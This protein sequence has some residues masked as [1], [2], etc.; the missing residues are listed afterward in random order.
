MKNT[1]KQND[2]V[3]MSN[4]YDLQSL[5]DELYAKSKSGYIFYHLMEYI[6][7]PENIKLAY[8]SIKANKGSH[9]SGMDK[10]DIRYL[11]NMSEEEYVKYIQSKFRNYHPKAVRRKEIPK[12]NGKVRPLGIPCITDRIIQQCILQVLEP[13]CEAKFYDSSY[14]FRPLRSAENAISECSRRI[15]R[16][17]MQYVVDVDIKGF[18]DNV[19]HRKLLRQIWTLGIR[20]TRLQQIIKQILK[21]PI[22]MPDGRIEYPT[23]GTPQGGILSPLLAN[24]VLNELDWWI[25][26]QWHGFSEQLENP[27]KKQYNPN[28]QRN[29]GSEYR[30]MRKTQL[31]EMYIVRYA[32]DFKIFCKT[33]QDAVKIQYAVEDFLNVRLKLQVSKEKTGITNLKRKYCEFLGFKLKMTPKG[34]KYVVDARMSDKAVE[35]ATQ[36]L[37]DQV[38]Q[39]QH[40]KNGKELYQRINLYNTM[41]M[42]I[43]NYYGIANNVCKDLHNIQFQMNIVIK[44][45][46]NIDKEGEITNRVIK[47]RYG[48][49]KQVR[50]LNGIPIVPIG[51]LKSRTNYTP[52]EL[53]ATYE[54]AECEIKHEALVTAVRQSMRFLYKCSM[55]E[56]RDMYVLLCERGGVEP[57]SEIL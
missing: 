56:L 24:I 38:K 52:T 31:K 41:V 39:I 36:K 6:E 14:G 48:K 35:R 47:Q 54:Q 23:K 5:Q 11:A 12:P 45:R 9:T 26:S 4:Y 2:K 25:D 22:K 57:D 21:A 29:M 34:K 32:D 18:F 53:Y 55:D 7:S 28:G 3:R 8:R 49:S 15:Q 42:G 43:Q 44:N 13:I 33:R 20:D 46:L 1:I 51:Y 40:P 30:I 16:S 10:N 27:P 37:K 19:N 50:W 17:H